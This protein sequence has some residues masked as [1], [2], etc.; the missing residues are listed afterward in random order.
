MNF[1]RNNCFLIVFLTI[2]HNAV[3][4]FYQLSHIS[5]DAAQTIATWPCIAAG[6]VD[7]GAVG[8]FCREVPS[9]AVEHFHS[10]PVVLFVFVHILAHL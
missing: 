4:I 6:G 10:G 7:A 1:L 3:G 2:F 5:V 9:V 8:E